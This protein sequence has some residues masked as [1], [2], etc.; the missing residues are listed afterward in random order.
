MSAVVAPSIDL[1]ISATGRFR[2]EFFRF[3]AFSIHIDQP[4]F[5]VTAPNALDRWT[6]DD[7]RI[8][9]NI[10]TMICTGVF[11]I[12]WTGLCD[13]LFNGL[14]Y[15]IDLHV[16]IDTEASLANFPVAFMIVN[17]ALIAAVISPAVDLVLSA[18]MLQT[19]VIS[20]LAFTIDPHDQR[21]SLADASVHTGFAYSSGTSVGVAT[22]LAFHITFDVFFVIGTIKCVDWKGV[23]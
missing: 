12:F 6:T 17:E 9:A 20:A 1:V 15:A 21:G 13:A 19:H 7:S 22:L 2:A 18:F 16:S 14:T 10:V 3:Y 11:T 4:V 23:R 8:R 5:A